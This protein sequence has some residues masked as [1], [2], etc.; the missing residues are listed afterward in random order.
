MSLWARMLSE[1]PLIAIL[2]GVTPDEAIAIGQ[3]LHEAGLV[4]VEVP[5]NS[6][7]PLGSIA[8]LAGVFEGRMLVGA[9][10]VLT[11]A[12]VDEVK[13]AG[14]Q[15][16]VSPNADSAVIK[17]TKA[18][19]LLSLPGFYT[20]SEAFAAIAAGADALKLFP[21]DTA[22]PAYVKALKAVLPSESP[23]FAVGGVSEAKMADY[24]AAGARG[25]G[26]GSGLY[27]PGDA[28]ET[29]RARA[30]SYVR[31]YKAARG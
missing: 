28:P 3:A 26:L 24:L 5:L 14:G 31:A 1:M 18:A 9:G 16:V 7:K 21:A 23:L 29:V 6:P 19:G 11:P 10:T 22:P 8:A 25:F 2:R 27:R 17:A 4:C 13:R 30:E 12:D 20:P 15:F